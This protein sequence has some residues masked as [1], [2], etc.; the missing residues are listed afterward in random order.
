M[1]RQMEM[2][3]PEVV[4]AKLRDLDVPGE[5]AELSAAEAWAAGAFC[6]DAISE[7]DALNSVADHYFVA[8]LFG[9]EP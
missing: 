8:S 2:F 4:E 6:E 5:M 1:G 7:T 9:E 3:D